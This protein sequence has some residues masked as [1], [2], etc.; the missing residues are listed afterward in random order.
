MNK[1]RNQLQA[2]FIHIRKVDKTYGYN[3]DYHRGYQI[4]ED[5]AYHLQ[6]TDVH[7][8]CC[9]TYSIILPIRSSCKLQ[10]EHEKQT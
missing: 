10:E 6:R 9:Q 4:K 5:F 1:K 3:I 2:Y 7:A 8:T